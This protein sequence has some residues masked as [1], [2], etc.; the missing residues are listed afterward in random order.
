VSFIE[1][2]CATGSVSDLRC[3]G[4][5]GERSTG[6]RLEN[7]PDRVNRRAVVAEA[8]PRLCRA[9]VSPQV[10]GQHRTALGADVFVQY[11]EFVARTRASSLQKGLVVSTLK[12]G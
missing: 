5:R 9:A 12:E 10:V 6:G 8:S 1:E 7:L 2:E 3:V 11:S 4:D